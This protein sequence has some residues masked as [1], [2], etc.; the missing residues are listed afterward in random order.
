MPGSEVN[1]TKDKEIV[2]QEKIKQ[3]KTQAKGIISILFLNK[4]VKLIILTFR[5][6][7]SRR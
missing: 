4:I 3:K 1:F 2:W 6:S 5:W 7:F